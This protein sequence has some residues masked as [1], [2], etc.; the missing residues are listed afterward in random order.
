M[1]PS[2]D[3][4]EHS[5]LGLTA[6]DWSVVAMVLIVKAMVLIYGVLSFQITMGER[7]RTLTHLLSIWNR[8]DGPQYLLIAQH[9]YGVAGDQRLALVFFPLYPW[10]IRLVAFVVRDPVVS[11]F[12]IS[13]IASIVA[14]GTLARL[15]AL[16]YS[17]LPPPR[18][19]RRLV[20]LHLSDL[21]LSAHRL[22]RERVPR[23]AAHVLSRGAPRALAWGRR[24]RRVR[25]AGA[26]QRN[27]AALR[28]RRGRAMGGV[29]F[30]SFQLAMALDRPRADGIRRLSLGQLSNYR[31]S[32]GVFET[33][34][35]AL[36]RRDGGA[37]AGHPSQL[38]HCPI[39]GSPPGRDDRNAGALLPRRRAGRGD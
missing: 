17:P 29:G 11:A 15:A 30:S 21:L 35:L 2:L 8:W 38:R 19:P 26:A 37:M 1:P 25:R 22:Q 13:T 6:S 20:P 10:L 39:L 4:R 27:P 23:A 18:P 3:H 36:V 24:P 7:V 5:S 31:R 28:A 33:G 12:A 9:G 32:A 14:G 16:D 34:K